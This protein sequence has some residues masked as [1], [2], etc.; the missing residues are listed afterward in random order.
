MLNLNKKQNVSD[1]E[2][3]DS[4]VDDEVLNWRFDFVLEE[5]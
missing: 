2:F 4:F 3:I 5:P 1:K